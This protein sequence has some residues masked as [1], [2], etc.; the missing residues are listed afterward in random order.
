MF[1]ITFK[2][3]DDETI[4][5]ITK[6]K[7][8]IKTFNDYQYLLYYQENVLSD[9]QNSIDNIHSQSLDTLM[10]YINEQE[11]KRFVK[12]YKKFEDLDLTLLKTK[13]KIK[14]NRNAYHHHLLT[15]SFSIINI[16]TI[17]EQLQE[18]FESINLNKKYIELKKD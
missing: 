9:I 14:N 13:T 5:I 7:K 3:H 15:S 4:S 12:I 11:F 18:Y 6:N 1:L 8:I 10:T 16:L 2:N 17:N